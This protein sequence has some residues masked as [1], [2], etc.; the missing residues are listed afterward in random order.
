M[1]ASVYRNIMEYKIYRTNDIND[2]LQ[3]VPIEVE[4][5]KKIKS[6][7]EIKNMLAFL[8][9]QIDSPYI[10]M[11]IAKNGDENI[12]GYMIAIADSLLTKKINLWRMWTERGSK[13]I[14]NQFESILSAWAKSLHIKTVTIQVNDR[15]KAIAKKW[16]FKPVSLIMEREVK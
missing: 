10:G 12:R 8:Q 3:C 14:A 2:I 1:V 9:H 6:D 13:G 5:Q 4:L 16:K 15:I 7:I 11:W